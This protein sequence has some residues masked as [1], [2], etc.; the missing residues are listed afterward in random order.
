MAL[1]SRSAILDL[2][3]VCGG[4]PATI[5]IAAKG[6]ST[7]NMNSIHGGKIVFARGLGFDGNVNVSGTWKAFTNGF[8]N[9]N[10]TWKE[11]DELNT[12]VSSTWK[13]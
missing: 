11:L 4:H 1:T 8:V 12:N 6:K 9:V 13:Q 2:N 10:G 5:A 7:I 3:K